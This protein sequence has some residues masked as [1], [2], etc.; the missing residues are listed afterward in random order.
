MLK[1]IK[2][3][4]ILCYFSNP[5]WLSCL[6]SS[7]YQRRMKHKCAVWHKSPSVQNHHA[8]YSYS[9]LNKALRQTCTWCDFYELNCFRCS[10]HLIN[11]QR[12]EAVRRCVKFKLGLPVLISLIK[13][14]GIFIRILLN[15][16][17]NIHLSLAPSWP[18][19][20]KNKIYNNILDF[21]AHIS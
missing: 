5:T 3:F 17:S 9:G 10:N 19:K 15:L 12:Y 13:V 2:H 7:C 16:A 14:E 4:V 21:F 18:P 8:L 20:N 1:T 11:F 6:V